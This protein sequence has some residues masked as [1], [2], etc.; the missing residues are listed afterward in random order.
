MKPGSEGDII[1]IEKYASK[2]VSARNVDIWLPPGYYTDENTKYPVL[3]MHDGQNLFN[4]ETSFIGVHWEIGERLARLS[5]KDT[6]YRV[7]VVGIWNSPH[8]VQEYAP[9]SAAE[10]YFSS[11]ELQRIINEQ[12]EFL[13]D[14]YLKFVVE[15]L[16]PDIDS[17][18]RTKTEKEFTYIMGS[19][20]GGLISLYALIKYPEIFGGAGCMSTH[21]PAFQGCTIPYLKANMIRAGGHKIYFDFGTRT[22]DSEYE[23]YQVQV[24]SI[25]IEKGY[26]HG[27]DWITRKFEGHEHS[28]RSWSE[29]VHIPL[30]FLLIQ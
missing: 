28:E 8:R 25:M 16:K 23:P 20:R 7:I 27:V 22:K 24:D 5:S 18:F 3:Y 14:N 19:S 29:R 17:K 9:Q 1:H 21:W 15:E 12:G 4:P 30:K 13:G 2:Y 26:T 6:R 10:T 11:I